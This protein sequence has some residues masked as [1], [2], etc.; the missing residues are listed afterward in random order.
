MITDQEYDDLAQNAHMLSGA[1]ATVTP[2]ALGTPWP[3]CLWGAVLIMVFAVTKE[4]W[5]DATE[6]TVEIRGSDYRDFYFYGFGTG[7]ALIVLGL[8]YFVG[9]T[10]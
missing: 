5:Y 7:I 6:E 3:W 9:Q 8:R 2:V 1:L 4:F 10:V